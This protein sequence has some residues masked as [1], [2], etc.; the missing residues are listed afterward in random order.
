[1]KKEKITEEEIEEYNNWQYETGKKPIYGSIDVQELNFSV[2]HL[3]YEEL[4][5]TEKANEIAFDLL[6]LI[7]NYLNK[8]RIEETEK[9]DNIGDFARVAVALFKK[10][11]PV[12]DIGLIN[13]YNSQKTGE[14]LTYQRLNKNEDKPTIENMAKYV[15]ENLLSVTPYEIQKTFEGTNKKGKGKVLD[16]QRYLRRISKMN[17]ERQNLQQYQQT[18]I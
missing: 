2:E 11:K 15:K 14:N 6:V 17:E 1:M 5:K 13:W 16:W 7:S 9:I 10:L 18:N 8:A 12:F 4:Y 3:L